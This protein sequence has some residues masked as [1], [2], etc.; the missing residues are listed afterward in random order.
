[1]G[2]L[3][4]FRGSPKAGR[5]PFN[6]ELCGP[7]IPGSRYARPGMTDGRGLASSGKSEVWAVHRRL[8]TWTLMSRSIALT[9]VCSVRCEPPSCQEPSRSRMLLTLASRRQRHCGSLPELAPAN[10]QASTTSSPLLLWPMMCGHS[11]RGR[12][13]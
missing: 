4:S 5:N 13:S 2:V 10:C 12:P 3:S 6:H 9:Q 8:R 11:S 7:W 1:M